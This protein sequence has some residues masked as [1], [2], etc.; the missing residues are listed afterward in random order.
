[1]PQFPKKAL[2]RRHLGPTLSALV[3]T[4]ITTSFLR[5]QLLKQRRIGFAC[6]RG[7]AAS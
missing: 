6:G 2:L 1:M 3:G 7:G 5:I 4:G